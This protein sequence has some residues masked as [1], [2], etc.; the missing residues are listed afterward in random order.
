LKGIDIALLSLTVKITKKDYRKTQHLS[1]G[2]ALYLLVFTAFFHLV[3][4][5]LQLIYDLRIHIF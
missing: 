3:I 5:A 2:N 4:A 1:I